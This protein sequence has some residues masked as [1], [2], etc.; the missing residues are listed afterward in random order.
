MSKSSNDNKLVAAYALNLWT[1]SVSQ[2]VDYNDVNIMK[3]E[4]D[5]IMNNLNLE[6]MPKDETLLETI[7]YIIDEITNITIDE[8]DRKFV[9]REYQHKLKNAVW[10]AVPNV[11]AIFATS[12]PV[13]I[14]LTLATQVGV[15]YMNYRRSKAE[16]EINNEK[17]R[18]EIQKNRMKHLN[19]LQTQLFDTAWHLAD[20]YEFPDEYRLTATQIH[21]YNKALM[22]PNSVKRYKILSSM[23]KSFAAYPTFWYHLGST[24]NFIYRSDDLFAGDD[25]NKM[26]YK[27]YAIESFIEYE[28]L[29][30]FNLLRHDIVTAS[31]ALEFLELQDYNEE[32]S[33]EKAKELIEIAEKYAGNSLDVIELCAFAYLRIRDNENAS[34]LFELLV[35]N[36]Y[37]IVINAQILSAIYIK[38]SF[39][40]NS[41]I[42]SKARAEYRQLATIVDNKYIIEMPA[43]SCDLTNWK[44]EW[45]RN[46]SIEDLLDKKQEEKQKEERERWERRAEARKF[47]I[48]PI[49]IVYNRDLEGIAEYFT[50]ILKEKIRS[51]DNTLPSPNKCSIEEYKQ[52]KLDLESQERYIIMLGDSKEAKIFY[53][54][55]NNSRWDFDKY[56]MRIMDYQDKSVI[57]TRKLKNSE[58]EGFIK[59]LKENKIDTDKINDVDSIDFSFLSELYNDGD[60]SVEGTIAKALATVFAYPLIFIGEACEMMENSIQGTKNLIKQKDINNLQYVAAINEFMKMKKL[61]LIDG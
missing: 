50:G 53:Q 33:P 52:N 46:D 21:E 16:L 56:G 17:A 32:N 14:G 45:D 36:N 6:N 43:Q 2:I 12:N 1:V 26:I 40:N 4:Y 57:L 20:A 31:W 22:E 30:K 49:L 60:S 13:A 61:D 23:K 15:G 24:A 19:A 8:G 25:E 47:F 3:Q 27:S 44:P 34:R 58:I 42:A 18:W 51:I 37:N 48:K 59:F 55:T 35:N 29:N 38:E 54:N 5:N 10:N 7:K 28:K 11:G 41:Q 9:E 39:N